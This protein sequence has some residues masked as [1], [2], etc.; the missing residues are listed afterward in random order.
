M[1]DEILKAALQYGSRAVPLNGKIPA[2]GQ[3]WPSWNAT[4][5]SI[6]AWYAGHPAA[7]I[8]VRCGNGLVV[9]DIDTRDGGEESLA[10]LVAEHGRPPIGPTVITGSGGFHCYFHGDCRS[11]NL[12]SIGI[13]GLEIKSDGTQVV[14][15]PSIHPDTGRAYAWHPERPRLGE[16]PLPELPA[17]LLE[18]AGQRRQFKPSEINKLHADDPLRAIP[19]E[20]Y[21]PALTGLRIGWDRK[22][23]CPF[24]GDGNASLHVYPDDGGW[25]CHGCSR[26]GTIYDLGAE[27]WS[28]GTRGSAFVELRRRL[29]AALLVSEVTV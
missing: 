17:W 25:Y 5:E 11:R 2:V 27:L 23:L 19:A 13:D 29:A 8:G 20:V 22:V 21:V 6:T 15:P 7:N 3:N 28:M 1:S 12:R 10:R 16:G 26:G 9:L 14:A 4:P 24:H 18:L